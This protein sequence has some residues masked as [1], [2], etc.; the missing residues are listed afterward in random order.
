MYIY[1]IGNNEN[2]QKI[3]F[4]KDPHR[5][6]KNLQTG[7][8]D[9]LYLHYYVEIPDEKTRIMESKIHSEI[10]YKRISGE[11]FNISV[12]DAKLVL[13]HAVIRWLDDSLLY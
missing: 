7:N 9:K 11:W 13:D 5:R 1:I 4:A 2:R 8:P 6:L 12:E 3:G 10:S